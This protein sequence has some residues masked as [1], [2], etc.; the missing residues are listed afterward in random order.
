M[1]PTAKL[2]EMLADEWRAQGEDIDPASFRYRDMADYAQDVVAP[3]RDALIEK[4][5]GY[6]ETDTLCYRAE[7]EE[8]LYRRQ[9]EVWEPLLAAMEARE[10][11]KMQRVSG[12]LHRPQS[13]ETLARLRTKLEAMDPYTLAALE[14]LTTLA[15]SLALGLEALEDG[16]DGEALWN[17][18]NL[19]EDW[20]ADLWGKDWETQ[21]R[22]AKKHSDFLAA[23]EFAK[24]VR[25]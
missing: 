21:E 7:P 13:P 6:A 22:R 12:V 3:D 10:G 4:L 5:L 14:Q 20:Q 17:A 24:A 8:P 25:E 23:M 19:E 9:Q 15:A 11:V 1:L 2:A 18:A 16:A